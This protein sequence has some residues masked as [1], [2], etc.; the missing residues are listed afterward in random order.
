M[1]DYVALH[2]SYTIIRVVL[3]FVAAACWVVY[4]RETARS[5]RLRTHW[6]KKGLANFLIILSIAILTLLMFAFIS[7]VHPSQHHSH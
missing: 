2:L 6:L 5:G 3:F 1:Y 7:G 4:F